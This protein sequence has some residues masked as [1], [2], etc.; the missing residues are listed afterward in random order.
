MDAALTVGVAAAHTLAEPVYCYGIPC[1]YLA[2]TLGG[3]KLMRGVKT[4]F[5]IPLAFKLFYNAFQVALSVY[6]LVLGLGV[7]SDFS[8]PFG[9]GLPMTGAGVNESL[10]HCICIHYLSKFVDYIDTLMIV[11]TKADKR[12]NVLHVYHHFSISMVWGFL[13]H[14]GSAY[15][16]VCYG[17][18][19]NAVIHSVM[20][21]YY[22]TA[23]AKMGIAKVIKK[24]VTQVQLVQFFSCIAHAVLVIVLESQISTPLAM[25]Q[26]GYHC[27]M[28]A[29]FGQFYMASYVKKDKSAKKKA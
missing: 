8:K 20:Y 10:H 15:G 23:A 14:I 19:I 26:F 21:G 11:L 7:V 17:A 6:T 13:I 22:F 29:L 9:I 18:W 25:L 3:Y 28:I 12:L 4:P 24:Y 5:Q 27:T 2:C 16:T 1:V